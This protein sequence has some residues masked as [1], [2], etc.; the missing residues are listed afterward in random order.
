M[1]KLGSGLASKLTSLHRDKLFALLRAKLGNK[2]A[3]KLSA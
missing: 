3:T 1:H 2:L